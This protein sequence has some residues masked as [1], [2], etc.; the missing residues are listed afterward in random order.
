MAFMVKEDVLDAESS[1][2]RVVLTTAQPRSGGW[3][4]GSIVGI[5]CGAELVFAAVIGGVGLS[6]FIGLEGAMVAT[7]LLLVLAGVVTRRLRR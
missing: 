5:V 6:A 1:T 3:R 7:V 2:D 4:L